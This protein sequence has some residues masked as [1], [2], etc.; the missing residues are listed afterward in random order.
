MQSLQAHTEEAEVSIMVT[1]YSSSMCSRSMFYSQFTPS[2][3]FPVQSL[4]YH[5]KKCTPKYSNNI[6]NGK[7]PNSIFQKL[8]EIRKEELSSSFSL[9]DPVVSIFSLFYDL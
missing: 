5:A 7:Q 4:L 1:S 8:A 6:S 3:M 9:A 2:F